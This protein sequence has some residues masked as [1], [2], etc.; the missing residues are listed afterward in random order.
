MHPYFSPD[1]FRFLRELARNN[2]RRWFKANKGRYI[3]SVR[4]P[5]LRFIEDFGK[6][7]YRISP[8]F[9]ADPRPT[10]GSMFR[11]Y[12]D[13]RFSKDKSPYKTHAAAQ[14]RHVRGRD[15]HAPGFYIHL[16]P[17]SV[18]GASGLWRS[19]AK[20]THLVRVRIAQDPGSWRKVIAEKQFREA[21]ELQGDSLKRDPKGFDPHHPFIEDIRR[22]DF[23]AVVEFSEREACS[24][25]FLGMFAEACRVMAPFM[26]FLTEALG[27]EW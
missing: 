24:P 12:R 10:G 17:G 3:Q 23:I 6:H 4:D 20:R 7:L 22:K 2:D 5:M 18:F 26:R 21:C 14:F 27:L 1:L 11:I 19:D 16:E 15:V 8:N 13:T 25:G 9:L